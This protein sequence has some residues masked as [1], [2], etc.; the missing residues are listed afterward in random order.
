MKQ[1][2]LFKV[3]YKTLDSLP[4]KVEGKIYM[5]LDGTIDVCEEIFDPEIT[6]NKRWFRGELSG[7][8]SID[9]IKYWKELA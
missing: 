7:A 1:K 9:E 2:L 3:G 8:Y 6:Y 5:I 4:D